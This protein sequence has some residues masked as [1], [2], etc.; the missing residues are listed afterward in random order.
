MGSL[1]ILPLFV[2][3]IT[4]EPD[5]I[6]SCFDTLF[7]VTHV[8]QCHEPAPNDQQGSV[9]IW[10]GSEL[11]VQGSYTVTFENS[12]DDAMFW[13]LS[14]GFNGSFEEWNCQTLTPRPQS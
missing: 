4:P 8:E 12:G 2:C 7:Q 5:V 9:A 3:I 14:E 6:V 10:S 11:M 13:V 1:A